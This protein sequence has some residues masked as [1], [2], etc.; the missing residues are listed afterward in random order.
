MSAHLD[1]ELDSTLVVDRLRQSIRRFD[2]LFCH[3]FG[4]AFTGM[5]IAAMYVFYLLVLLVNLIDF[6]SLYGGTW[7]VS[8]HVNMFWSISSYLRPGLLL[9]HT[10]KWRLVRQTFGK[11]FNPDFLSIVILN[12]VEVTAV[13]I[14]DTAHQA[15]ISHTSGCILLWSPRT[16]KVLTWRL[17]STRTLSQTGEIQINCSWSSGKELSLIFG[18]INPFSFRRSSWVR[19]YNTLPFFAHHHIRWKSYL[20]LVNILIQ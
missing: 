6:F 2:D 13:V 3:R 20:L 18:D 16:C 10:S 4:A 14:F 7:R 19:L 9:L 15:I 8:F 11:E 1:Y 5:V 17:Q 12:Y